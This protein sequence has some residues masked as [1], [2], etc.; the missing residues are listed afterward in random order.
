MIPDTMSPQGAVL[1]LNTGSSSVKFALFEVRDGDPEALLTLGR[2]ELEWDGPH[3]VDVYG[4][5]LAWAEARLDGRTLAGV[6]HRVVHGGTR[7]RAPVRIDAGVMRTLEALVPLAPLHQPASLEAIRRVAALRPDTPQ[8]A[9]FDTAFHHGH[10]PVVDRFG[11]PRRF[12]AEG[13]K[14]YGF[15]GLSYTW[16]MRRLRALDPA[17]APARVIVAHLGAGA[18]LCAMSAGRSVDTTMGFSALDGLV[19]ATRCGAL[20]SRGEARP[21]QPTC[22]DS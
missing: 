13:V 8:A 18:S 2:D 12:E 21:Q 10:A 20:D 4:Q 19:M 16:V 22:S 9:S 5:V 14:R 15:H 1:A 11:L 3:A 6:G 7:Y 17:L